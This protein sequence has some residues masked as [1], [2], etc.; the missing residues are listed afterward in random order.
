MANPTTYSSE[1]GRKVLDEPTKLRVRPDSP[2]RMNNPHAPPIFGV[3]KPRHILDYCS[4]KKRLAT[5]D[6]G[7]SR[8]S[9]CY[10]P[11]CFRDFK[12]LQELQN[13]LPDM[14]SFL[15]ARAWLTLAS[16]KDRKAV[17]SMIAGV[18]EKET[19]EKKENGRKSYIHQALA[20]TFHPT[21]VA[22]THQWLRKAGRTETDAIERLLKTLCSGIYR[23]QWDDQVVLRSLPPV[24]PPEYEIDP[25][26]R[27]EKHWQ[28]RSNCCMR[29]APQGS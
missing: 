5:A 3:Q 24:Q 1:F 8:Q 13:V 10:P 22:S 16:E 27:S 11:H 28:T 21:I 23:P 20:E 4:L 6:R 9:L 29:A 14:N 2:G 12:K 19:R 17:E 18:P 7:E 25:L 15:A 26:W